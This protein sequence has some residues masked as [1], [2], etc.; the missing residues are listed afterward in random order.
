MP[1]EGTKTIAYYCFLFKKNAILEEFVSHMAKSSSPPLLLKCALPQDLPVRKENLWDTHRTSLKH[2]CTACFLSPFSKNCEFPFPSVC[3]PDIC[4]NLNHALL[5]SLSHSILSLSLTH[6]FCSGAACQ[7]PL[8]KAC[9][10]L[11]VP[12]PGSFQDLYLPAS[13]FVSQ[14]QKLP[15]NFQ[16]F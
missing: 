5:S 10:S 2:S 6:P 12:P 15:L 8:Y 9:L 3:F 11:C 13:W 7:S 14:I 4:Q 16:A 1:S